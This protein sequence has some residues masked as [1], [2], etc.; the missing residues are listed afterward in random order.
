MVTRTP[1]V[2]LRGPGEPG[3]RGGAIWETDPVC[4]RRNG[5]QNSSTDTTRPPSKPAAPG[6]TLTPGPPAKTTMTGTQIRGE[7][8]PSE[9][10]D[11][12]GRGPKKRKNPYHHRRG[13]KRAGRQ[14]GG[15]PRGGGATSANP[16]GK[17]ERLAQGG[18]GAGRGPWGVLHFWKTGGE[19]RQRRAETLRGK[20]GKRD[21]RGRGREGNSPGGN[22]GVGPRW[23]FPRGGANRNRS[24]GRGRRQREQRKRGRWMR[25]FGQKGAGP[26]TF[27]AMRGG[28]RGEAS[29]EGR[30]KGPGPKR[31]EGVAGGGLRG[32]SKRPGGEVGRRREGKGQPR[33]ALWQGGKG[34][35]WSI[36]G[37]S[38]KQRLRIL[39]KR[40]KGKGGPG[41]GGNRRMA[42]GGGKKFLGGGRK[43]KKGAGEV[44]DQGG[45]G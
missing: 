7:K 20:E 41:K 4:P 31:V 22:P 12:K 34:V 40:G 16:G 21:R 35:W 33:A 43:K 3:F 30:G 18:R 36:P 38:R 9:P 37:H 39:G 1:H 24:R 6:G 27:A 5:P 14:G 42:L 17:G 10:G 29:R 15:Q 19:D 8:T 11:T 45:S 23:N 26:G 13:D 25:R 28:G 32:E 44:I 2:N